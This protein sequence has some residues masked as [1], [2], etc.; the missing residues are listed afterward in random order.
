VPLPSLS[1]SFL[2]AALQAAPCKAAEIALS[3]KLAV[4]ATTILY[5]TEANQHTHAKRS[6]L[7]SC[8]ALSSAAQAL[9]VDC[10]AFVAVLLY[11]LI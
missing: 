6:V 4:F 7:N 9:V 2:A 8:M 3:C 11:H 5:Q 1:V 10:I